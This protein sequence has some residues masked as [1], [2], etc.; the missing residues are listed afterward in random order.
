[1]PD[2]FL[3]FSKTLSTYFG[4][5]EVSVTSRQSSSKPPCWSSSSVR[6]ITLKQH[7][8]LILIFSS[9]CSYDVF[10]FPLENEL[11]GSVSPRL[12]IDT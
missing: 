6:I 11:L 12:A 10:Y 3:V 4:P 5:S 8:S 1:M 9:I 7:T 2:Y